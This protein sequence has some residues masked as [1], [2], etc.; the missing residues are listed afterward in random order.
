[1]MRLINFKYTFLILAAAIS[2]SSPEKKPVVKKPEP[3]KTDRSKHSILC[4]GDLLV[5]REAEEH[6]EVNGKDYPF[7]KI[8]DEFRKYDIV[9]A[10]FEMS[11][12]YR[13]SVHPRKP[14]TFRLHPDNADYFKELKI[15]VVSI[16][17]NH[18]LDYGNPGLFDTMSFLKEWGVFYSGAGKNLELARKPAILNKN[19]TDVLFLSYCERPPS[20]FYATDKSPGTAPLDLKY[21]IEDVKK[22]KKENNIVLVSLHWGI[23]HDNFPKK[24][25]VAV[26]HLIIDAGAD[27]IIGHHPHVPQGIEIYNGKPV[28]YSLGNAITGFYNPNYTNNIM[29]SLQYRGPDLLDIIIIPIAGKFKEVKSQPHILNGNKAV[30]ILKHMRRVSRPFKTDIVI[31]DGR[32]YIKVHNFLNM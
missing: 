8:E 3:V 14:Y 27:G 4:M 26:A 22:H 19:G 30:K 28:F 17:N 11:I 5:V 13:G 15:D 21:I 25:Q 10:N 9:F 18:I 1:M 12:T 16:A 29:A 2:C 7:E 23:E 6:L 31:K 20:D 24:Y 32:G